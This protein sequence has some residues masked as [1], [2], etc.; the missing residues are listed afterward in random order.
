MLYLNT[1]KYSK[2]Q[3]AHQAPENSSLLVTK[4]SELQF[5]HKFHTAETNSGWFKKQQQQLYIYILKGAWE[6]DIFWNTME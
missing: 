2:Y 1:K 4:V 5:G 3:S 6:K